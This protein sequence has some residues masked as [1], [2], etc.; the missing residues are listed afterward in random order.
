V[1]DALSWR[2]RRLVF[3]DAPL[4]DVAAEFNRYNRI[5]IRIEGS[6]A[7]GKQLTGIFDADRPQSIILF[8]SKDESLSVQPD[9]D[10]W[11]IRS[12]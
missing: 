1:T 10:N 12:R 7:R 2:Q 9:G 11:V 6:A 8:A 4:A 5:Q 3:R